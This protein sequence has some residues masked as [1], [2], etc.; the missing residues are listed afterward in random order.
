MFLKHHEQAIFV[1]LS[2]NLRDLKVWDVGILR[3]LYYHLDICALAVE[4]CAGILA[5]GGIYSLL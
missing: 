3:R 4:P 1:D 5:I 2:S